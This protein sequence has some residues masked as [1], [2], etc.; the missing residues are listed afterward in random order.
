MRLPAVV[1]GVRGTTG[2]DQTFQSRFFKATQILR[3]KNRRQK[4]FLRETTNILIEGET[5]IASETERMTEGTT[6]IDPETGKYLD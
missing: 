6:N 4:Y 1:V 5:D 2:G 3:Q